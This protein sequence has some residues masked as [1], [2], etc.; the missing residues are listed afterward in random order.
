[1]LAFST[2]D[3]FT[4]LVILAILGTSPTLAHPHDHHRTHRGGSSNW[5]A[6]RH[7][8]TCVDPPNLRQRLNQLK[9][10][11]VQGH[12]HDTFYMLPFLH[13]T[14]KNQTKRYNFLPKQINRTV[15]F[16]GSPECPA[17][18]ALEFFGDPC[19]TYSTVNSDVNRYPRILMETQC[20]CRQCR[21]ISTT[22]YN[23]NAVIPSCEGV[24]HSVRV[25]RRTRCVS[26]VYQ[27]QP[28]W[29]KIQIGCACKLVAW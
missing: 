27:Y 22:T 29:E 17:M 7:Q 24:F 15:V 3:Q 8:V 9:A 14:A 26:G 13:Q 28:T 23:G 4:C 2:F 10:D 20:R 21:G 6:P 11:H 19:P 1:M 25:L 5:R 12:V 18:V 16:A